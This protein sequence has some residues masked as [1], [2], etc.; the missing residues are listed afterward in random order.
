M[1]PF[2]DSYYSNKI[3][4]F[5]QKGNLSRDKK[6]GEAEVELEF[7]RRG[8]IKG[9]MHDYRGDL[10]NIPKLKC[11]GE[12]IMELNP[13]EIGG[14]FEFIR[15]A[16]GVVGVVG[17][18]LGYLVSELVLKDRVKEVIVFEKELDIIRF[19]E[20][21]LGLNEK[22]KFIHGDA[23]TIKEEIKSKKFNFFFVDIYN[24]EVSSKVIKDYS[25]FK[26]IYDIEEYAF[27]GVEHFILSLDSHALENED[28]PKNWLHMADNI[29]D[30]FYQSAYKENFVP[31]N[32][33]LCKSILEEL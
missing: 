32:Y 2:K 4:E 13:I 18:G 5:L 33:K 6:I 19:Y 11:N 30:R 10:F 31:V 27:F 15:R 1:I 26:G 17:L 29:G 25:V 23:F 8:R 21:N 16:S 3:D 9:Y 12:F 24:E 20:E 14:Y 22:V 28:I 7:M